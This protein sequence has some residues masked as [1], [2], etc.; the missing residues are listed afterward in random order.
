MLRG[1]TITN[2]TIRQFE[3]ASAHAELI[4][5]IEENGI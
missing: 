2:N 5:D 3:K 1:K 4:K